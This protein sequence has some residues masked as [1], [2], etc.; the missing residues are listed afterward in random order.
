MQVITAPPEE[1][2]FDLGL[3]ETIAQGD[4]KGEGRC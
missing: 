3:L 2:L 1:F 4:D